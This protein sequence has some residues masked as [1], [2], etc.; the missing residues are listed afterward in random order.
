[1]T[2]GHENINPLFRI[3]RPQSVVIAGAS[4]NFM[5][6]GSI[7][8]INL[9]HGGFPGEV[10]FLH[11]SEKVVLGHS[12]FSSPADLPFVPDVALLVAPTKVTVPLLDQLGERGVRFAVI[13][14]AGFRETGGAGVAL[15]KELVEV[16][17]RHGIRFVGPNCIGVL[18]A[19]QRLNLTVVPYR[20]RPGRLG[21][22]SQSGTYVSQT[23]PYLRERGIRYS[24]AISIG[25]ATDIDI[26]DGLEYLGADEQTAAIILYIE[27]IRRGREFVETARRVTQGKPVVALYVGGSEAGAR[28]SMSHTGSLGGPDRLLDGIFEQAG[29]LRADSLEDLFGWGHA[30]ANMPIP[31]GNRVAVL[32]HSGGPATSMADT[33]EKEGLH[34]PTFSEALQAQIRPFIEPHASAKNPVD[35]T[36]SMAHDNFTVHIPDLLFHSDEVDAV[37]VHGMMDTGFGSEMYHNLRDTMAITEEEFIA[38]LRFDLTRLFALPG[39]TGKPLTASN[40]LRVDHAAQAFRDNDVPLFTSPEAAVRAMSALVRYG[41]LRRRPEK[42]APAP[43]G[44]ETSAERL[45]DGLLD[46]AEAKHLLA[47]Y[48]VPIAREK[49]V[50]TLLEVIAFA[51]NTGYPIVLKGLPEGVAHKSEAGLVHLDLRSAT[52]LAAAWEAIEAVAPGCPRLAAEMLTGDRELLV[53]M[54]R[55][56]GF[57]PVVTLGIGGIYTEAI[58]DATMRLAPINDFEAQAM[59]DS[60]RGRK[61]LAALRGRPAVDRV[62]LARTLQAVGYLALAHPEI[63]EI[64]INPLIV[65]NGRPIAADALIRVASEAEE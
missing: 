4:N 49:R 45:P 32:T 59:P 15:E 18:N 6:M 41:S 57:G 24:Q 55:Y 11:P 63:A 43:V 8:A 35:L 52:E 65:V 37:L 5:K 20:D 23:L 64:D 12:A 28:S 30:L 27:G 42:W 51:E 3:M 46:E 39:E 53:G 9:L 29:I 25:N 21:L 10:C 19:H 62:C 40:F 56:P 44:S 7:Q 17:A 26:V 22:I 1:M 31:R 58:D 50:L 61:L 13:V 2:A 48:G 60:L 54:V 47:A 14:T 36:F 33:C 38:P 16:A 34:L